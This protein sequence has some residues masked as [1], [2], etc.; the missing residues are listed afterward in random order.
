M[1]RSTWEPAMTVSPIDSLQ[2]IARRISAASLAV[3]A[4]GDDSDHQAV[5]EA[6]SE[7]HDDLRVFAGELAR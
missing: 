2:K 7:V 3:R 4:L 5:E 6:L 1:S